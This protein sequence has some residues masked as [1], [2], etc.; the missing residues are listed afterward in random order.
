MKLTDFEKIENCLYDI[1]VVFL[2]KKNLL[3][4]ELEVC[5]IAKKGCGMKT[6]KAKLK[7]INKISNIIQ[8]ENTKL[9]EEVEFFLK[10]Y[11]GSQ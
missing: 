10:L 7:A 11:M 3:P 4:I 8:Y 9:L 5:E 2:H 1:E 6:K